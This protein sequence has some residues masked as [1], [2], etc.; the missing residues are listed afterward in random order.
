MLE[1]IFA[2]WTRLFIT[3]LIVPIVPLLHLSL[4]DLY[5]LW[6]CFGGSH[7][8]TERHFY[9]SDGFYC[10]KIVNICSVLYDTCLISFNSFVWSMNKTINGLQLYWSF[11]ENQS[12][13]AHNY[14]HRKD[15]ICPVPILLS[16]VIGYCFYLRNRNML[17]HWW[18]VKKR[19][20]A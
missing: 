7:N 11:V 10:F 20:R 6:N 3:K 1:W 14:I 8:F 5:F 13:E 2:D 15:P 17:K 9:N 16:G 12:L 18:I 4:P 19:S